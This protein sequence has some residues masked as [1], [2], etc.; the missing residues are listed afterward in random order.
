MP[1]LLVFRTHF[2]SEALHMYPTHRSLQGAV[3]RISSPETH[4]S[5]GAEL[6]QRHLFFDSIGA[7]LPEASPEMGQ[8]L[9]MPIQRV[10]ATARLT[11]RF[12]MVA[13]ADVA[14]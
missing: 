8:V 11:S 5:D 9:R 13:L 14:Q 2:S 4:S 7:F 6:S 12:P 3:T 1:M 10:E